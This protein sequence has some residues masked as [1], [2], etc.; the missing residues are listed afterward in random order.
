M[1]GRRRR[2]LNPA[3]LLALLGS[4]LYGSADFCG[5][6]ASRRA[7][8]LAVTFFSGFAAIAILFVGLPLVGGVTRPTDLVWGV[9]GGVFG[10]FGAM[11]LYRAL[12]I[13]PV[14]V[15]S[16]ILSLIALALPLLVGFSL[17]ERPGRLA[18]V[19]L[20]LVPVA[21]L[22][23]A[24]DEHAM[25]AVPDAPG[26]EIARTLAGARRVLG[27]ALTAGAVVGFFLVFLGRIEAG[28]G[29]WPLI[30]ARAAGLVTLLAALLARR[31][32]IVPARGARR[33]AL[34]TGLLDSLANVAFVFAVQRA[35]LA[36][37]AALV[38]LAPA[39][40]VLLA[41]GLLGERWTPSQR[42]GLALALVAGACIS[43]G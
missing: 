23:L 35:S 14:S 10:G 27:P 5:G 42:G 11:L 6:M 15:A 2:S 7:P 9:L 31:E 8:A 13:G 41:R 38:S 32:P 25:A 43:A 20:V 21:V 26:A 34:V 30:V 39:T 33:I 4:L 16:P 28:A 12:A 29:L 1:V 40:T 19:G 22:L 24:R 17:G 18:V 37:V 36:L 3:Y